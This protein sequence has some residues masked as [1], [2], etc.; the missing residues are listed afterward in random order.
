MSGSKN[1]FPQNFDLIFSLGEACSCTQVLR[2]LG[3]QISSYPFDWLYGANFIDRCNILSNSFRN[4]IE[5][6]DL[7]Y[8][9]KNIH[10]DVYHNK[11]NDIVFNHDFKRNIPFDKMYKIVKQKYSR[12]IERLLEKLK[13]SKKIL[14]V[15]IETPTKNHLNISSEE[16]IN[17]FE[18]IQNKFQNY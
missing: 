14:I 10:C 8:T 7:V 16:I 6:K 4:F 13:K 1:I 11:S 2:S 15:Y 9:H 3:L 12:R 5:K 18:Q 17:G